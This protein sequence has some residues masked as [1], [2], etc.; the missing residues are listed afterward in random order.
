[1]ECRP[2]KHQFTLFTLHLGLVLVQIGSEGAS[3]RS[4]FPDA[5]LVSGVV[6][7]SLVGTALTNQEA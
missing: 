6:K 7:R 5:L 2:G 3:G 4:F 1:M